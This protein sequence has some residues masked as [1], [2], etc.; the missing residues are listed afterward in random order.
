MDR[1]II[2]LL[3]S[4]STNTFQ[5]HLGSIKAYNSQIPAFPPLMFQS[6][7]CPAK[8]LGRPGMVRLKFGDKG[9]LWDS[10]ILGFI[11]SVSIPRWFD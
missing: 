9:V 11:F 7:A 4:D 1:W 10:F 5:S 2:G 6:H 8:A 3:V